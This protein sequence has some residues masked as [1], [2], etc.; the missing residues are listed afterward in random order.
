MTIASVMYAAKI[1]PDNGQCIGGNTT[2]MNVYASISCPTGMYRPSYAEV[3]SSCAAVNISCLAGATCICSPCRAIPAL[4]VS[5]TLSSPSLLLAASSSSGGSAA[6]NVSC[7]KLELCGTA[8]Q[9]EVV[10]VTVTDQYGLALRQVLGIPAISS[11][12]YSYLATNTLSSTS[13]YMETVAVQTAAGLS[14]WQFT[15]QARLGFHLLAVRVNKALLAEAPTVL[16][17]VPPTCTG[18]RTA[19]S[20]GACVCPPSAVG[21]V[22]LDDDCNPVYSVGGLIGGLLGAALL[23]TALAV[24]LI[25]RA[26]HSAERS[27]LIPRSAVLVGDPPEIVGR[28]DC[29]IIFKGRYRETTV[30]LKRL[31]LQSD[32]ARLR[33]MEDTAMGG[34]SEAGGSQKKGAGRRR[35]VSSAGISGGPFTLKIAPE[36]AEHPPPSAPSDSSSA[37]DEEAGGGGGAPR[38]GGLFRRTTSTSSRTSSNSSPSPWAPSGITAFTRQRSSSAT[39]GL[40]VHQAARVV[41]VGLLRDVIITMGLRHPRLQVRKGGRRADVQVHAASPPPPPSGG[42]PSHFL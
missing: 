31:L 10:T 36:P 41:R 38:N 12:D 5:L 23:I 29:D 13:A 27:V 8:I 4:M 33:E 3:F 24:W 9:N 20:D 26:S 22:P 15:V 39:A 7:S 14:T 21:G 1:T 32:E 40:A 37:P 6:S 34:T 28:S 16:Q 25:L 18:V 42:S 30:A 2:N 11:V 19:T 17:G 35:S